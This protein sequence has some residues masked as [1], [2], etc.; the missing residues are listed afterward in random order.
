[1]KKHSS[2]L[3]KF[4]MAFILIFILHYFFLFFIL[5]I[6]I[7]FLLS[8]Y[9]SLSFCP[10]AFN[11]SMKLSSLTNKIFDLS[12][13]RFK[14]QLNNLPR[15]RY[16]RPLELLL[17]PLHHLL[18]VLFSPTQKGKFFLFFVFIFSEEVKN[19]FCQAVHLFFDHFH[20]L[21]LVLFYNLCQLLLLLGHDFI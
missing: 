21:L 12:F 17:L 3:L 16:P 15:Q 8:S 2:S 18:K 13:Q 7:F 9:F 14:S 4:F 6:V 11:I 19:L 5:F 10:L 20:N 1:M